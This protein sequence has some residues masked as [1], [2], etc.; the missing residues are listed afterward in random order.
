MNLEEVVQIVKTIKTETVRNFPGRNVERNL[1]VFIR[2]GKTVCACIAYD[3]DNAYRACTYAVAGLGCEKFF[4]NL[5][6]DLDAVDAQHLKTFI[7]KNSIARYDL[8]QS[9]LVVMQVEKGQKIRGAFIDYTLN[10]LKWGMI[11]YFQESIESQGSP[12][13]K[14]LNQIINIPAFHSSEFDLAFPQHVDKLSDIS[15]RLEARNIDKQDYLDQQT[16]AAISEFCTV[17]PNF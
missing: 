6:A 17:I 9:K 4:I 5:D 3:N 15:D 8:E 7:G 14:T 1:L 2:D 16:L 10:P 12:V 13:I 11:R